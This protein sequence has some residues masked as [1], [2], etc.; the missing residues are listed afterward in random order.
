MLDIR[1]KPPAFAKRSGEA[2]PKLQRRRGLH[3]GIRLKPDATED[4][5]GLIVGSR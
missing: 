3:Q 2:S 5:Q 1:L 4:N